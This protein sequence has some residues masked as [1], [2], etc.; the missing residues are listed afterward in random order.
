MLFVIA[1]PS[2]AGKT[3]IVKAVLKKNRD[4]IFSVSATTRMKRDSEIDG[5]DYFFLSRVSQGDWQM[6]VGLMDGAL[7]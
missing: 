3:S 2:G 1:A 7:N 5:K 6:R 4:L